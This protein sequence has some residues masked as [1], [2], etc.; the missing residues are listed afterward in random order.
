MPGIIT[1]LQTV[2]S[3]SNQPDTE[4]LIHHTQVEEGTPFARWYQP[5]KKP[6]PDDDAAWQMYAAASTTLRAACYEHYE[7]RLLLYES[8]SSSYAFATYIYC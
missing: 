2:V 4:E 3:F 7:V 1:K 8:D 6:L 5:G